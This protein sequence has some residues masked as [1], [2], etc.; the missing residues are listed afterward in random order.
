[1]TSIT[2]T[3]EEIRKT[4]AEF[5]TLLKDLTS[6]DEEIAASLNNLVEKMEG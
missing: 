1:M 4:Q 5:L 3:D 2:N 6:T